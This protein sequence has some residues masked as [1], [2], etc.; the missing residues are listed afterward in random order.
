MAQ[1]ISYP[2]IYIPYS[3]VDCAWQPWDAWSACTDSCSARDGTGVRTR[4][5]VLE[6]QGANGG[7]MC[8]EEQTEEEQPCADECP[9]N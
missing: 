6:R 3:L 5:R 7:T 1:N 9:G 4:S 2:I 8:D